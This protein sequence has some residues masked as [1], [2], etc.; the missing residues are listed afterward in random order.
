[1]TLPSLVVLTRKTLV[2]GSSQASAFGRARAGRNFV[3]RLYLFEPRDELFFGEDAQTLHLD[4]LCLLIEHETPQRKVVLK[5]C[6]HFRLCWVAETKIN[7]KT[8]R[9]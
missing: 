4:E 8:R 2:A 5:G 1:M 7:K 9:I 6:P 3:P